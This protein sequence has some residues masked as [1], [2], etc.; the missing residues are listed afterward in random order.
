MAEAEASGGRR[1]HWKRDGTAQ[2]KRF[3]TRAAE[4]GVQE[5]PHRGILYTAFCGPY[6][7]AAYPAVG[8]KNHHILCSV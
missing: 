5:A 8:E 1:R 6:V 2:L 4:G 3:C 7:R